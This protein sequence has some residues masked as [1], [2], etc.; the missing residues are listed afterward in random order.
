MPVFEYIAL[1][2]SGKQVKG[3]L[4]A[5]NMRVARQRLRSQGIFPTDVKEAMAKT[6]SRDIKQLFRT[7]RVALV[8]LAIAT[9]QLSTLVA[10][11]LPLV[12]ALAALADQ[13]ESVTLKRIVIDIK[14]KVEEGSA[15]AKAMANFPKAFPKL[16]VNMVASG[17]ASGTLDAVLGNLADYLETQ[18]DLR[19]KISA[20]LLYPALMLVICTLVVVALL[21]FVVPRIVEIFQKKKPRPRPPLVPALAIP[22]A[23]ASYR[24]AQTA[25]CD[26]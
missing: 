23:F 16:Y 14:E 7:D 15:L 9:R 20:A 18:L 19:R 21:V 5:E 4:D 13:V 24:S 3:S 10:A 1:N 12:S 26:A 25:H 17:E 22:A 6:P 11:G 8:D 2:A